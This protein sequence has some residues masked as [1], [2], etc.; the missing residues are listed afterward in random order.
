MFHFRGHVFDGAPLCTCCRDVKQSL[1]D[2]TGTMPLQRK[3]NVTYQIAWRKL[4]RAVTGIIVK[5]DI[6]TLKASGLMMP[7]QPAMTAG[8][9]KVLAFQRWF[10]TFAGTL[11]V[12]GGS[13]AR[14]FLQ[15]AYNAGVNYGS[16]ATNLLAVNGVLNHRLD[17]LQ[18]LAL[19]ELQGIAEAVSQQA[20][21]AVTNGLLHNDSPK[22]IARAINERIDAVGVQRTAAM[23]SFLTV[24]T[25]NEAVLDTYAAAKI[26]K[27]ELVPEAVA[28]KKIT[29]DARRKGVGSRISRKVAPSRSTIQRIKRAERQLE[30]LGRVNVRTAGDDNVCTVCEDIADNGPYSI[31]EARSLIPAHPNCRCTFIPAGDKRFKQDRFA[32]TQP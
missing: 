14:P 12:N 25:F 16:Q 2:P 1:R 24:K 28:P 23:V 31:D 17:T 20:V 30:R 26:A 5:T 8:G 21:R 3:F 27:V 29:T 7:V 13:Q 4:K 6:L 15:Q 18:T 19:V 10:D 9:S 22:A 32:C 11:I